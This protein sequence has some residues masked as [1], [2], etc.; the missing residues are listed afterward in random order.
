M[1][2]L[3][4]LF[5]KNENKKKTIVSLAHHTHVYIYALT[6]LHSYDRPAV[7][8][9]AAEHDKSHASGHAIPTHTHTNSRVVFR[10]IYNIYYYR[11]V[12]KF[13]YTPT[14]CIYIIHVMHN[15]HID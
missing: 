3:K 2:N 6:H 7:V 15:I 13:K 9:A 8:S 5:I 4:N 1:K 14:E 11:C 10:Y 12:R